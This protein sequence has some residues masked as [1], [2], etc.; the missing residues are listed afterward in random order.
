MATVKRDAFRVPTKKLRWRCDPTC[1]GFRTTKDAKPLDG[2]LGQGRALRAI[3]LGL[4]LE[5]HGYNIYVSGLSGTGKMATVK[6]LLKRMDESLP[7][8]R[9]ILY[10]HNFDEP[11][12]PL[13]LKLSPGQGALFKKE[14]AE[15][16]E[17]M[18]RTIPTIFDNTE[19]KDRRDEI[20][21]EHR[22]LQKEHFRQLESRIKAESFAM[23]QVQM[24][25]FTRPMILPLIENQ[26]V[27]FEQLENLAANGNFPAETLA[28]LKEQHAMLRNE[29]E[30]TMKRVR[31]IEKDMKEALNELEQSYGISLVSDLLSDIRE[32]FK[33]EAVREYLE[34]VQHAVLSGLSRFKDGEEQPQQQAAQPMMIL[35]GQNK[36]EFIEFQVNVLVDNSRSK[37][38]PVIIENTPTYKNLFGFIEKTIGKNGNWSTDFTKIR[39][40]SIARAD[41]GVLVID[42][43]D[44]VSEPGVWINLKRAMKTHE[45]EIEGW[46]AF[47][48]MLVSSLKPEPIPIQ[49]KIVAIGDAWLFH[50]LSRHDEDFKKIFKIKAD[51]DHEMDKNEEMIVR[52]AS[53]LHK[54]VTDENLLHLTSK[55]VA[56]IVEEGVRIAGTQK[57]LSTRFSII[58]DI[59]REANYYAR[60]QKKKLIS[61][62]HIQMALDARRERLSLYEDKLQELIADGV[63][64]ISS[65]GGVVGQVNA[66]A[67]SMLGDYDFG[68]PS[69]I[70]AEVGMGSGSIVNIE[71][72]SKLSGKIHDK[73]ILILT[74]YLR[75]RFAHD[76]P[77]SIHASLTFEQSYGGIDGDSASSTE[78][79]ALLS[80]LSG[81]PIEQGIAVTGS[82]N[83]KGEVQPIGG[84][85]EK[86]EGF[87]E[88]CKARG[89]NGKQGVMIPV[90]NVEDLMLNKEVVAAVRRG[91]FH[92]WAVQNLDEGISVLTGVAAGRRGK[93]G[94]YPEG[95]VNFL[96]DKRLREMALGLRKFGRPPDRNDAADDD[97]ID[98]QSPVKKTKPAKKTAPVK[99]VKP[100]KKTA[101]V[102]SKAP[103]KKSEDGKKKKAKETKTKKKTKKKSGDGK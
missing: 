16:V 25:P 35:E 49:L 82:M 41:G 20:I 65:D 59:L 42:L 7:P 66:L 74:G 23:V 51:F 32:K 37:S 45:L 18:K 102:K 69:R 1:F 54:V 39:A 72:E 4:N 60:D 81:L 56:A 21:E 76:K 29:L 64:M 40:G 27:Q 48:W 61:D 14:M 19:Y 96:V 58:A 13:C 28:R 103:S 26:P 34:Q 98:V 83:Q 100:A 50:L 86:I 94:N 47:Y 15:F 67:V 46:D 17:D 55:G 38:R 80:E 53:F 52:Y 75:G 70:T 33:S 10:V 62:K 9:D 36:D 43:L 89:L 73:G 92:I 78:M 79:Y 95:T 30:S 90:Q 99:K 84:A 91:K 2:V 71:R 3:E 101:P 68:H 12:K 24:G 93:D 31:Q 63:I 22:N 57:K 6:A 5:A 44:A 88:V 77:L 85:N 11:Q 8:A 87:F 97:G